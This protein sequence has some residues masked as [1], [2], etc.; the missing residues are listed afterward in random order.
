MFYSNYSRFKKYSMI[1]QT[2]SHFQISWIH[3]I[4]RRGSVEMMTLYFLYQKIHVESN[5]LVL[6][7]EKYLQKL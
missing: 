1:S 4:K 5:K 2:C 6:V 3:P 7:L